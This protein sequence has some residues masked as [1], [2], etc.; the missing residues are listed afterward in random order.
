[1]FDALR[2]STLEV[3]YNTNEFFTLVICIYYSIDLMHFA[4]ELA[5]L[6][7]L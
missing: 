1:M 3:K 2:L 7:T 5:A 6:A 4:F